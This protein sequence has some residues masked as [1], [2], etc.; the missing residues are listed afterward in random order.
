MEQRNVEK[1]IDIY[2]RLMM[3]EEVKRDGGGN[4]A[5]YE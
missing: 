4:R 5:L 2:A 1:A 3:G